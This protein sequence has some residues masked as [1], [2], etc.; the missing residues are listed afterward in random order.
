[1]PSR[2]GVS[3]VLVSLC[4][5]CGSSEPPPEITPV[6]AEAPTPETPT[7]PPTP[8]TPA[9]TIAPVAETAAPE[10]PTPS[11]PLPELPAPAAPTFTELGRTEQTFEMHHLPVRYDQVAY[12]APVQE[13][14]LR[15][16]RGVVRDLTE[17]YDPSMADEYFEPS[18]SAGCDA[19]LALPDLVSYRC[20]AYIET[21]RGAAETYADTRLWAI[22]G[23]AIRE[24]ENDDFLVEGVDWNT[25]GEAYHVDV[26]GLMYLSPTGVGLV[27]WQGES[28]EIPY[29][30]LG[31]LLNPS[32]AVM[33]V[34]GVAALAAI[35]TPLAER[36]G[37]PD[38]ITV[39]L[40]ARPIGA[41]ALAVARSAE[42]GGWL[43]PAQIGGGLDVSASAVLE[44][45]P[46]TGVRPP[47]SAEER[48]WSTPLRVD[49]RALRRATP[50]RPGPRRPPSGDALP[51]GT[52]VWAILGDTSAGPSRTGAGQW[53]LV[54]ASEGLVGWVPSGAIGRS[55]SPDALR[56]LDLVRAALPEAERSAET[57][58]VSV[59]GGIGT[60]FVALAQP[61]G[62]TVVGLVA[63]YPSAL[64]AIVRGSGRLLDA[65]RVRT[66]PSSTAELLVTRWLRPEDAGLSRLLAHAVPASGTEC[67]A[68]VL[69][70]TL[71][72]PDAPA[73]ERVTVAIELTRRGTYYPLVLRGPGRGETLHTWSGTALVAPTE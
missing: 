30:H 14:L 45:P 16:L 43:F 1:M 3:I 6:P 48:P 7:A 22:E 37:P 51:R 8:E 26:D 11:E 36:A 5:A 69:D 34:P 61:P 49:A 12:P 71:P 17:T 57:I 63:G 31:T 56:S 60:G 62:A 44:A 64:R 73:R 42:G 55:G 28:A 9:P 59:T 50:L 24:V 67:G 20:S 47:G 72:G 65:W 66:S 32:S 58:V 46:A 25:L 29:A 68:P 4:L 10:A 21:G 19:T 70:V 40:P 13:A 39:A 27:D 15:Q 35:E 38:T 54:A 53:T 52:A 33:R 2:R 41:A 18:F 23:E